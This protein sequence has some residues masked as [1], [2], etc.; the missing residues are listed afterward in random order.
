MGFQIAPMIDVVFVIMLFFMVMAGAIRAERHLV[1]ALPSPA[2]E[3]GVPDE[4]V[5]EISDD[6]YIALNEEEVAI[7][8]DTALKQLYM[9]LD[10]L[11]RDAVARG[12]QPILVTIQADEQ[13]RYQRIV[14]VLNVLARAGMTNVTFT[15]GAEE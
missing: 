3:T 9:Q 6:G 2:L 8:A 12:G 7:G 1:T 4:I 13:A 10:N 15:V 11:Q 5:I 14:D